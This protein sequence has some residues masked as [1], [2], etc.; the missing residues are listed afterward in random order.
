ME[1]SVRR[2]MHQTTLRFSHDL[3]A[4]LEEEAGRCG[5]SVA[6]WVRHA[7][8]ER[9]TLTAISREAHPDGAL[10]DRID[11]LEGLYRELR[12]ESRAL[13][14][15]TQQ[16]RRRTKQTRQARTTR[17]STAATQGAA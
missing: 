2:G 6:Q 5:V 8:V 11:A 9:L 3:W 4:E 16:V 12:D 7:A 1:V 10:S 15:Q 13:I 14:E 17:R